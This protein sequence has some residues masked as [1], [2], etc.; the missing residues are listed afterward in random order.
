MT[1]PPLLG[2][3][4]L[5]LLLA[6]GSVDAS[7]RLRVVNG[8]AGYA[9]ISVWQGEQGALATYSARGHSLARYSIEPGRYRI[10]ASCDLWEAHPHAIQVI[11][12]HKK[13]VVPKAWLTRLQ[14]GQAHCLYPIRPWSN[15]LK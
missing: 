7:A 6:S 15:H 8:C 12:F 4:L 2:S 9:E 3:L 13:A 14:A 5:A 1:G 11:F 10:S